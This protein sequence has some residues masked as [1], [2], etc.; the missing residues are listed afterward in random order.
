MNS[1]NGFN[2]AF[3]ALML[4][5][6]LILSGST[7]GKQSSAP[8]WGEAVDGL[9]MSI[10]AET[11]SRPGSN[12]PK[13]RVEFRNTGESDL[14]LRLGVMLANG[15]RQYPNAVVLS[16]TDATGTSRQ[17]N[18]REPFAVAGRLDPFILP[19]PVGASFSFSVDLDNYWAANSGEFGYKLKPGSYSIQAQLTGKSVSQQDAN[20]DVKGIALIPYWQGAVSSKQLPFNVSRE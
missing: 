19:M 12:P 4:T 13:F 17:L 10:Y 5:S 7:V 15:K 3:V 6:S 18:L 14:I 1:R 20:L 9:Q 11:A 8:N 2:K 16:L